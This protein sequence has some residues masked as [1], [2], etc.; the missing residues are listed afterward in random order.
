[1]PA[2][3]EQELLRRLVAAGWPLPAQAAL[4][5]ALVAGYV[6]WSRAYYRGADPAVRRH[7]GRR[8]GAELV[9]VV[10]GDGSY[11]T[12]FAWGA[13]RR[14]RWSWGIAA[15]GDRTF[16]R[17]GVVALLCV[18][19]VNVLAGVVPVA[20]LL[21]AFAGARVLSYAV[22]LPACVAMLAIYALRWSGRYEVAGMR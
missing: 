4:G 9:W 10:R 14:P 11:A 16:A 15:E 6:A 13:A 7:L 1:M 20:L 21:Y 17:D 18:L 12:P 5:I 3:P 22:F 19:V 8:L 2:D